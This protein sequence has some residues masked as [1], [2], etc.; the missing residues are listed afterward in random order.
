L[1]QTPAQ[2]VVHTVTPG[3]EEVQKAELVLDGGA[4]ENLEVGRMGKW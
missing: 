4:V 3:G 2:Q 1:P